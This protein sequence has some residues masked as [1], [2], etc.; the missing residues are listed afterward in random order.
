M[1]KAVDWDAGH[2]PATGT[3]NAAYTALAVAA[4]GHETGLPAAWAVAAAGAGA[5]GSVIAGK[6]REPRL[7]GGSLALRASSWLAAGGWVSWALA[8]ETV[9]TWPVIGPLLMTACGLGSLASAFGAKRR[10]AEERANAASAALFRVRTGQEWSD[11][12][13]RVC[14]IEGCIVH[15][16]EPW[17]DENGQPTGAGF[18]LEIQMP[19]GGRTWRDLAIN[20]DGL[21]SDAGLPEGCGIE[22]YAGAGRDR[23]IVKVQLVNAL[24]T[25]QN[26]PHDASEL[27]F[28]GSFDIG[29]LR[30]GGL[31][32]VNIREFSMMLAGAKRTGKTNELLAIITRLLRMPNLLV[33]VIDF[34][35]GGLALQWLRMWD[36]L[37][38][39]GRPPIDWVASTPD[40]AEQ[41]AEAAVRVAKARKIEYQQLMADANTDLLPMTADIPGILIITDE[42]A[43]VYADPRTQRVANPMKEVLRIAGAS[44]VNQI[45]CFLRATASTTGDTIIKS[46]SQVRVGMRM[47]DEAEI[48]Y[49][50]GHRSGVTPQ[51]M[52]ERGYGALT[53]DESKSASVFRGWRVLPS[54]IKWF[55]ENTAKYRKNAGLD[56]VSRRAAGEVYRTRWS[57]DRA[58]YI[59]TGC[60]TKAASAAANTNNPP[61]APAAPADIFDGLI[62]KSVEDAKRDARKAIEDAGGPTIEEQDAF[63]RV[64]RE[65]G[66]DPMDVDDPSK[67]PDGIRPAAQSDD[68]EYSEP[69]DN[70][71]GVVFG[72]IQ[73]MT[74]NGGMS[75]QEIVD[76][77]SKSYDP[78]DLPTR[79]TITRWLRE[80]D[81]IYKPTGYK[82]Y[83]I[84][85]EEGE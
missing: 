6:A 54:D 14:N 43:E 49:L 78:E 46:Q 1:A 81:R 36:E 12:I 42:G 20:T 21:A 70:L 26:V 57:D 19:P 75:I 16:I 85:P 55:V 32:T 76:A 45:N 50:L 38:R 84:K 82:K 73:A 27:S 79:Q 41:L 7:S 64:L 8:Q 24:L 74:P 9:W 3:I 23:T 52:P 2:T 5:L 48:S 56:D 62:P 13:A 33:W 71:R 65:A 30:D 22:V 10:R 68:N 28:E 31:A 69:E 25:T 35:G 83:A 34:N 17:K 40:E 47:A 18:T 37:G 59:F 61:E 60:Q 44:G 72:L 58:G 4:A 80:D 77:L 63:E 15:N 66:V 39:P 67:W 51:D 11:R 53:M 29:V